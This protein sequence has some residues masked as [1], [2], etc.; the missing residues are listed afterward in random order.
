MQGAR[1]SV[2]VDRPTKAMVAGSGGA[3]H[4]WMRSDAC[5]PV[6]EMTFCEPRR[7]FSLLRAVVGS[8]VR[9][10]GISQWRAIRL[11]PL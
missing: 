10:L 4:E 11:A 8:H 2:V 1:R 7:E 9:N 3:L 5:P 6:R